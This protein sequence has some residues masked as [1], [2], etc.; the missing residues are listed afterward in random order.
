VVRRYAVGNVAVAPGRRDRFRALS[1]PHTY[2]NLKAREPEVGEEGSYSVELTE[3][4]CRDL[5]RPRPS[6]L[7]YVEPEGRVFDDVTAEVPSQAELDAMGAGRLYG[8]GMT[9]RGITVGVIDSGFGRGVADYFD[10]K[11]I[12]SED[13]GDP[14]SSGDPDHG[15]KC[16]SLAVP[17]ASKLV[18]SVYQHTTTSLASA[19]YW[20]AEQGVDVVSVSQS[21]SEP[22]QAVLDAVRAVARLDV[23]I[24]A[25]AGNEG[26]DLK[27]YPSGY[28]EC[29]CV[30]A[31]AGRGSRSRAS[32]S[33]YGPWVD[34][35][36]NGEDVLTYD[37]SGALVAF[38]G[39]SAAT[40]L[41]AHAYASKLTK[42]RPAIGPKNTHEA[43][44]TANPDGVVDDTS[45]RVVDATAA[46]MKMPDYCPGRR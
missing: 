15:S 46:V 5:L 21:F 10:V 12:R 24:F 42:G 37:G 1:R 44:L 31:L 28:D 16:A 4:E 11:A 29:T 39:T 9:G 14:Y 25:S 6:N 45:G 19:L 36:V 32:S 35:W 2:R 38:S 8:W 3:A 43:M 26:N 33:T 34:L 30:G 40:P 13:G 22:S 20:V 7:R 18:M 23:P 17:R 41:A 27:R